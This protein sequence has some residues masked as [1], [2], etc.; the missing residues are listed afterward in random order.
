MM[1]FEEELQDCAA[2]LDVQ[3]ERPVHELELA[4]AAVEELLHRLQESGQGRLTHRNVQRRKAEFTRERATARG[5]DVN[6]AMG[7]VLWVVKAVGELES[8]KV[9]QLGGNDL[10]KRRR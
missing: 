2:G 4:S 8:R 5:F 10:G 9:R 1:T 6:D 3:V 7:D